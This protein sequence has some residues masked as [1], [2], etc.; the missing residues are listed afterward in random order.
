VAKKKLPPGFDNQNKAVNQYEERRSYKNISIYVTD[1]PA[2]PTRFR[3]KYHRGYTSEQSHPHHPEVEPNLSRSDL[4][5]IAASDSTT[6]ASASNSTPSSSL[7]HTP[8]PVHVFPNRMFLAQN[9]YVPRWG[10]SSR[11]HYTG[12][13]RYYYRPRA[14]PSPDRSSLSNTSRYTGLRDPEVWANPFIF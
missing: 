5:K 1:L 2:T 14:N 9:H 3:D 10:V 6:S 4:I 13:G 7:L 8:P 12:G 11:R